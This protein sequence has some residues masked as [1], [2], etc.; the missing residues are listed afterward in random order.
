MPP[1]STKPTPAD[2]SSI[3]TRLDHLIEMNE[4]RLCAV[5]KNIADHEQRLRSLQAASVKLSTLAG[6]FSAISLP[7][8]IVALIK[9]VFSGQ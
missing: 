4:L 6:I 2:L 1:T 3:Q 8:S 7:A 9:S 5:E